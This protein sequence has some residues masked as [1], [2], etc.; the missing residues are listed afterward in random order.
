MNVLQKID[1]SWKM[2]S[3]SDPLFSYDED[4][5]KVSFMIFLGEEIRKADIGKWLSV[6]DLQDELQIP[7]KLYN[8]SGYRIAEFRFSGMD[9]LYCTDRESG[10]AVY[11]DVDH[12]PPAVYHEVD[13]E[14]HIL[15][16]VFAGHDLFLSVKARTYDIEIHSLS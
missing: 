16:Y 6:Y 2:E 13:T 10:L 3:C 12:D 14:H 5:L 1:F 11:A 4:G 9:S 7:D 15:G 8:D